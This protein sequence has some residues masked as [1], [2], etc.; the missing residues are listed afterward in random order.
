MNDYQAVPHP[1]MGPKTT[2][3]NENVV[4]FWRIFAYNQECGGLWEAESRR[5]GTPPDKRVV[6]F[7][8]MWFDS[9]GLR[10][11]TTVLADG[12]CVFRKTFLLQAHE[13]SRT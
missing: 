12:F 5:C 2:F 4:F 8:R 13:I 1:K 6:L 7:C 3:S 11:T 10:S 9:T